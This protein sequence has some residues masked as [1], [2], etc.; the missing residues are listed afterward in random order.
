MNKYLLFFSSFIVPLIFYRLVVFLRDGRVSFLRELTGFKVHHYHY[1]I[2]LLTVAVILL[3]FHEISN[4]T[5]V[6]AGLG[7]GAVLDGFLSSFFS[8]GNRAG[9]IM[10]YS[11]NLIPTIVLFTGVL[12]LAYFV[13]KTKKSSN[14]KTL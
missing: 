9:E 3:I 4:L 14:S 7:L 12:L 2:I 11:G 10:N 8:S 1:G 13:H 5:I 6:V